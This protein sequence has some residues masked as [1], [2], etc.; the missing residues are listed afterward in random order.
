M[1]QP[2]V[3]LASSPLGEVG[4]SAP[5]LWP[6]GE[7]AGAPASIREHPHF[8]TRICEHDSKE[9]G[10]SWRDSVS[11]RLP[12]AATCSPRHGAELWGVGTAKKSVLS[13]SSLGLTL[14]GTSSTLCPAHLTSALKTPRRA[15]TPIPGAAPWGVALLAVGKN[16]PAASRSCWKSASA[17]QRPPP[18]P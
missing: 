8:H 3:S 4:V 16:S 17:T 12:P 11:R 18:L 1:Q 10:G 7:L 14:L 13:G 5:R 6:G 15:E 9:T 2:C